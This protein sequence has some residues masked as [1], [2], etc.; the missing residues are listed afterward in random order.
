[1]LAIVGDCRKVKSLLMELLENEPGECL[2][3]E[4]DHDSFESDSCEEV[5]LVPSKKKARVSSIDSQILVG[6]Y[7]ILFLFFPDSA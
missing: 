6:N 2:S 1:M 4:P 3:S 5:G 7:L